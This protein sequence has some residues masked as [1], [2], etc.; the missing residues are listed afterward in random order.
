MDQLVSIGRFS[1]LTRLSVKALRHYDK[2]DLLAPAAVDPATGYRS[3]RLSQ[4]GSAEAIRLLRDLDMPLHEIREALREGADP[5]AILATHRQRLERSLH[6]AQRRLD[7]IERLITLEQPLV[8]YAVTTQTVPAQIVASL[9]REVTIESV[10]AAIAEGFPLLFGTVM[11]AGAQP[12]G[13]PFI[14]MHDVIDDDTA[15]AIEMCMPLSEACEFEQP[16]TCRDLEGAT[17]A[18]ATHRG[19]YDEIAPAYHALAGWMAD[20]GWEPA[21]PPRE[22]YLNDPGEVAPAEQLT[23]VQWPVVEVRAD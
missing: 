8:P 17:V 12:A 19:P 11:G 6:E 10:G 21:G 3:Y 13:V 20:E 16:V 23:E 4:A 2:V 18:T 5:T 14:V 1:E 7:F 9:R 22:I 15:G